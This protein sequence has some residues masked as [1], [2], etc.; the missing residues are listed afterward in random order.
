MKKKSILVTKAQGYVVPFSEEKLKRSLARSG[1]DKQLANAIVKE[2]KPKLYDGIPT[3]EIYKMAFA[4][5]K[6]DSRSVAAKYHLKNGIMELGPSGYPFEKFVGEILKHQGYTVQIG[7]IVQ[8]KCV[9]HEV[10]VIAQKY[11]NHFMI[12][13]KYHNLPGN[14]SSVKTS[15]YIHSRFK[16]VEAMWLKLKGHENKFH[17]G[18]LVTNTRFT[19]DAIQYGVCA[20]LKLIGWDYPNNESLKDQIDQLGLYPLTCLTSL[21]KA[22]KVALLEKDVVLAKEIY[23]NEK[24]LLSIGVKPGRIKTILDE[25]KQLCAQHLA[26]KK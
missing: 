15:L 26:K 6:A 3:K 20:G 12:E 7:E 16:D 18:W 17:Q 2:I 23:N 13:C 9:T 25:V 10:D 14:I 21:T 11:N 4:L 22:E 1:A 24:L 8:G 19:G 5:L